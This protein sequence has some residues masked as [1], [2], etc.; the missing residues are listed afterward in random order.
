MCNNLEKIS[1]LF[2]VKYCGIELE[3][4]LFTKDFILNELNKLENNNIISSINYI[5]IPQVR[6]HFKSLREY[7]ECENEKDS[8]LKNKYH[9]AYIK[10]FECE[11]KEYGLVGGKTNYGNPDINFDKSEDTIARG[12]LR[13]NGYDWCRD[14]LIVNCNDENILDKSKEEKQSKFIEKFLQRRFNLFDS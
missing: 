8:E 13:C 5:S 9:F 12:F 10:F 7:H 11:G 1:K 2:K 6:N 4:E 3:F 14:V